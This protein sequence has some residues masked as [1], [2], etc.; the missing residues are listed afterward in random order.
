MNNEK[1]FI[2]TLILIVSFVLVVGVVGGA[3]YLDS[4]SSWDKIGLKM[5]DDT[6]MVDNAEPAVDENQAGQEI[7][8]VTY[9]SPDQLYEIQI[10]DFWTGEERAGAAIFYSY[11]P[12]DGQPEQRAKIEIGRVQNTDMLPTADW[13]EANEIDATTAQQAVFGNIQGAMVLEDNTETNPGDIKSVIYMPVNDIVLVV[14]AESFGGTRDVA[15]QFFNAI[16]N[17]WK[18]NGEVTSPEPAVDEEMAADENAD[19]MAME[20]GMG[21]ET[22]NEETGEVMPEGDVEQAPDETTPEVPAEEI[23]E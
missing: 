2:S 11:N 9:Q 12:A 13:L 6:E 5:E 4:T 20:E 3:I 19:D 18:W 15:V 1:G 21:E 16:L 14:T 23:L 22:V 17:S 7:A 10:P 8:F